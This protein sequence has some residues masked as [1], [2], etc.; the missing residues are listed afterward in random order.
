MNYGRL[1][2]A[3]IQLQIKP[4][5]CNAPPT[6]FVDRIGDCG[7]LIKW[8]PFAHCSSRAGNEDANANPDLKM[9]TLI[10][11]PKIRST[12]KMEHQSCCVT[13][14]TGTVKL[15]QAQ[16]EV[17]GCSGNIEICI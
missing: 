11:T 9:P 1:D 5:E 17:I 13:S 2:R 3:V 4:E 10:W 12:Y 14:L 16:C 6:G 7:N 8:M 15:V